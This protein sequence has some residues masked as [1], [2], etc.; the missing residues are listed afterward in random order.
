MEKKRKIIPLS[1]NIISN[2]VPIKPSFVFS[3]PADSKKV[4]C[5]IARAFMELETNDRIFVLQKGR[6][7]AIQHNSDTVRAGFCV[8]KTLEK[9]NE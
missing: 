6:A 9:P 5:H 8:S 2:F 4:S 1:K 3:F 7:T